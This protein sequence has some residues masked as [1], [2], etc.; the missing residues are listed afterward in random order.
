M[1]TTSPRVFYLDA[2]RAIFMSLGIILHAALPF[3]P[4]TDWIITGAERSVVL[5]YVYHFINAFRMPGFFIIAG[6]F[7]ALVIARRGTRLWFRSRLERLAVPL[8]FAVIA[9]V[10]LVSLAAAIPDVLAGAG[11]DA[12]SHLRAALGQHLQPGF[13]WVSHLWFILDLLIYATVFAA[14]CALHGGAT[15][16][17]GRH[18]ARFLAAFPTLLG[19]ALIAALAAYGVFVHVVAHSSLGGALAFIG[20]YPLWHVFDGPRLAYHAP[21]FL[22]GVLLHAHAGF[23]TA[24]AR[25]SPVAWFA[26]IGFLAAFVYLRVHVPHRD[27]LA[28]AVAAPTA[29]LLTRMW[30]HA[31][32]SVFDR[33]SSIVRHAVDGS[34]TVYI[35]H[36]PIIVAM[37]A[38]VAPLQLGAAAGFVIVALATAGL[39]IGFHV[40]TRNRP[41]WRYALNGIPPQ[42]GGAAARRAEEDVRRPAQTM[43]RP[44]S[45]TGTADRGRDM[46]ARR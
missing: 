28:A 29:I 36:L 34:Y 7:A 17:L 44:A 16:A 43:P 25:P 9:I 22:L 19:S 5:G 42:R 38:L 4:G 3:V 18:S 32:A 20:D 39:S 10:P 13:H 41:L 45:G 46:D 26:G 21:Y 23:L 15:A 6:Y 2:C 27:L 24:F 30:M 37:V 1:D 35:I 8:V 12:G 40:A 31:A 33:P 14:V 11:G